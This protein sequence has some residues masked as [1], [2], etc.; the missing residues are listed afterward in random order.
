MVNKE[1]KLIFTCNGGYDYQQ[2]KA[3]KYL[4]VNNTY[5][6]DY[7]E[8]GECMSYVYLKEVRGIGFNSVMFDSIDGED[9]L[10]P[11]IEEYDNDRYYL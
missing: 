4:K 9:F 10:E 3:K 2:E 6:L 7:C 11:Y 1:V 5:T 8:V